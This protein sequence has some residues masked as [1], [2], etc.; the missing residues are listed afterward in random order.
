MKKSLAAGLLTAIIAVSATHAQEFRTQTIDIGI[1][2]D[3]VEKSIEFYTKALGFKETSNFAVNGE[4][5]KKAG[6]TDGHELKIRV[7]KLGDDAK[8]TSIK[9]MELPQTKPK[10]LDNRF[11]HSQLGVSYLTVH[12]TDINKAIARAA[13]AGSKV[14]AEGP[15]ALPPP[16]PSSIFIAMVRDPDG[17]FIEL[18]GPKP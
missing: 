7:L 4:A 6:L 13:Q 14:V 8:A 2:V 18:V 12:V 11:L 16:L 15:V 5:C 17:N 1:V 10:K 9:L 3:D